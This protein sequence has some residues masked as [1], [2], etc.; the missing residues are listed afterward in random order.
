MCYGQLSLFLGFPVFVQLCL[1]YCYFFNVELFCVP[2]AVK[3]TAIICRAH[4]ASSFDLINMRRT[5]KYIIMQL[6]NSNEDVTCSGTAMC[7]EALLFL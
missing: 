7:K 1:L 5:H 6:V 4:G 2:K 3:N